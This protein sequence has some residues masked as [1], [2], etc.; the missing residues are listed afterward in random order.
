MEPSTSYEIL[1]AQKLEQAPLPDLAD[2]I[3]ASIEMELDTP[4][5]G[6]GQ[7]DTPVQNPPGKG[8]PGTSKLFYIIVPVLLITTIW[9]LN[10]NKKEKKR[11]KNNPSMQAP[12]EMKPADS[13]THMLVPGENKITLPL[14]LKKT[15]SIR[16]PGQPAL[17]PLIA[18][19][20]QG[21]IIPPVFIDSAM[22]KKEDD[23]AQVKDTASV[24][25]PVKKQKGVKGIKDSDYKIITEKKDTVKKGG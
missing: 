20:L 11:E 8:L 24:I 25:P 2:S 21:L 15:D 19:T 3:W 14:D 9:L 18:D 12:S 7:P 16:Q 4:L 23:L 1:I 22:R 6:D 17:S 10:K 13:N 5:P